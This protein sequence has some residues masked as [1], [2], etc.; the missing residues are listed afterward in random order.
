MKTPT[1]FKTPKTHPTRKERLHA[2]MERHGIKTHSI[3]DKHLAPND[4]CPKWMAVWVTGC[5]RRFPSYVTASMHLC[6]IGGHAGRL[7]DEAGLS[8]DAD[9]EAEAVELLC[10][11]N[12]I[13]FDV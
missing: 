8:A 2:F 3:P 12:G 5:V 1:L 4:D 13:Q 10:K 11:Q 6:E 7:V 9:T